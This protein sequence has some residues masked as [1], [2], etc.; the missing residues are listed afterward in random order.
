M[1]NKK[2]PAHILTVWLAVAM[3]APFAYLAGRQSSIAVLGSSALSGVLLWL[4][5]SRPSERLLRSRILCVIEFIFLAVACAVT[6][7]WS[8]Q[9]WPAAQS[10]PAVPLLLLALAT[11]SGFCGTDKASKGIG[12]LFWICAILY[13]AL[14][15]LGSRN[16]QLQYFRLAW[17]TP[18]PAAWFV[19]LLPC[20]IRF[21][22][23][24]HIKGRFSPVLVFLILIVFGLW[25][26][27]NLSTE[28]A[29]Q[30]DWPFYR[31][32]ES[33]HLFGIANRVEA[34]ISVGA[35]VGY[36]AL[37]SLLIHAG[38]SLAQR[39]KSGWGRW[40]AAAM[41]LL[42]ASAVLLPLQIPYFVLAVSAFVLWIALPVLLSFFPE[43]SRK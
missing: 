19:L 18:A 39:V 4:T 28:A 8:A 33:I 23:G 7:N 42:A 32:G 6:A 41:G 25:T 29:M 14:L 40:G 1:L 22:P 11:I 36:Y 31:A 2:V 17:E 35:T 5:Q 12:I 43:K 26:E 38:S 20:V 27:G 16:V 9:A 3:S 37:L 21:I 13:G 24:A 34:F 10:Y 30:V 15:I